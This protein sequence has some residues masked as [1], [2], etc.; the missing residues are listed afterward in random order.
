MFNQGRSGEKENYFDKSEKIRE[1]LEWWLSLYSVM[2]PVE[3][4]NCQLFSLLIAFC[5]VQSFWSAVPRFMEP[6]VWTVKNRIKAL[7]D[8]TFIDRS[9]K[10]IRE[11]QGEVS[12]ISWKI[13]RKS[14]EF[15][16]EIAVATLY[17]HITFMPT[18]A[19]TYMQKTT[20]HACVYT[21]IHTYMLYLCLVYRTE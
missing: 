9:D 13:S 17:I 8:S 1:V 7:L 5:S 10:I 16:L 3:F 6:K 20:V 11:N 14:R 18:Y 12:S 21:N 19:H 2:L 4:E 15:C